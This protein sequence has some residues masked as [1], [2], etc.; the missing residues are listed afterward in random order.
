MFCPNCGTESSSNF[1]PNCGHALKGQGS[2]EQRQDSFSQ[3]QENFGQ[4]QEGAGRNRRGRH[5]IDDDFGVTERR[6]FFSEPPEKKKHTGL[7]K[8]G[9]V[10]SFLGPLAVI[11]ILLALLDLVRDRDRSHKHGLSAA[12]IIIGVLVLVLFAKAASSDGTSKK[13]AGPAPSSAVVQQEDGQ[14]KTVPTKE[15]AAEETAPSGPK[16]IGLGE[17]FGNKTVTGVVLEADLDYKNYNDVWTTVPEGYKAV[18]IRILVTNVSKKTNYV[19]VGDLKCYADNVIT[20]AELISGGIDDYNANIAPGRSA[21]LG[22][23]YIVPEGTLSIELEYDPIGEKAERQIIV[24][25][26]G[27][28]GETRI[29]AG[30]ELPAPETARDASVKTIGIGDGFGNKTITGTVLEAD[31]DYK[32]YNEVWTDVPEGYKAVYIK[33]SLTNIS[34]EENYVSAGDFSCYAD[35]I[36]TSAELVSGGNED[37]NANIAPGRSA[38][39]GAMYVIPRDTRSIELEYDPIG[40]SADRVIIV[41]Q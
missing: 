29:S 13:A 27:A 26:D 23:L 10:L 33:I 30:E 4:R 18:Y 1:C 14:P 20:S 32:N 8:A 6:A 39:L 36:I 31:L 35:N 5:D 22:A 34:N 9:F 11:G 17:E 24:I 41:I 16:K 15:P 3:R 38:V 28:A 7:A 12:A 40:E 19:S 25:Q 21:I 37:Y 2:G